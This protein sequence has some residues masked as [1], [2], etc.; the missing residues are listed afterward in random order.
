MLNIVLVAISRCL[1]VLLFL[2]FSALD[3]ALN[4]SEAETQVSI[5]IHNRTLSRLAILSAGEAS[6]V[7]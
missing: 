2:P 5:A 4:F 6:A 3:K 7:R 1:L